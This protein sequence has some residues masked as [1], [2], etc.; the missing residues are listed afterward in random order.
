VVFFFPWARVFK[1][2]RATAL[3][4]MLAY[5]AVLAVGFVYA[6]KKGAFEWE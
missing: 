1:E 6:W 4:V 2:M 5:I 3:I